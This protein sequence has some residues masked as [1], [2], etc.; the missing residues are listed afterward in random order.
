MRSI[1]L[2]A[3]SVLI[4]AIRR[5]EIYVIVLAAVGVILATGSVK[6]FGF[7]GMG[8][9]YREISLQIMN[10]ATAFTVIVLASR[11]L[12]RE[13]ENRTIYPLLAK[14]VGRATFLAGKFLGVILAGLFCYVIFIALFLAGMLYLGTSLS[15]TLFLE[16]VYLQILALLVLASL[17]FMLSL[18]FNID[19]AITVSI[20]IFVLGGTVSSSIDYVYDSVK[21]FGRFHIPGF[22]MAGISVGGL[23]MRL[24]NYGIP[25]LTLFDL[26][27][28]VVHA[29]E[30]SGPSVSSGM[31][32]RWTAVDPWVLGGLTLYAVAFMTLYLGIAHWMFKRRAL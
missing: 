21:D 11:Q 28:K 5:R 8:K 30:M 19:A 32:T 4:E 2:I 10:L 3:K 24:L 9:F 20:L 26:S 23:L 22:G 27:G 25:Q 13:F 6:F 15:W 7:Q 12:P 29:T 18:L 14:P 17:S 1:W 16:A 31:V